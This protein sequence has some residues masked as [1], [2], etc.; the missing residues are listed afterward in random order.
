[1]MYACMNNILAP[2]APVR[3]KNVP[4]HLI[5]PIFCYPKLTTFCGVCHYFSKE[6][7]YS[8]L[9]QIVTLVLVTNRLGRVGVNSILDNVTEFPV[10]FY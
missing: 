5:L 10:F 6:G 2:W 1:M 7:G 9:Q 3:A 4:Y 8:S